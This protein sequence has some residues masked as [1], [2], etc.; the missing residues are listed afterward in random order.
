MKHLSN[1]AFAGGGS[2]HNLFFCSRLSPFWARNTS[3]GGKKHHYL[4]VYTI[5]F[6]HFLS[7]LGYLFATHLTWQFIRVKFG[8]H[9]AI[10]H[11][12]KSS[13]DDVKLIWGH[14]TLVEKRSSV[15]KILGNWRGIF[16][17]KKI[18]VTE[19]CLLVTKSLTIN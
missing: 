5:S 15:T 8:L 16:G 6:D 18:F 4:L 12:K 11:A 10:A 19:I 9:L 7:P 2:G 1:L 3:C 14:T 17:D 13:G